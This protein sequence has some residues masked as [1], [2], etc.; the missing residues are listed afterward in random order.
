MTEI[1]VNGTEKRRVL[2][3]F[4]VEGK[5]NYTVFFTGKNVDGNEVTESFVQKMG[6][7]KFHSIPKEEWTK[8]KKEYYVKHCLR[9]QKEGVSYIEVPSQI[10]VTD[11]GNP[12]ALRKENLDTIEMNYNKALQEI[13]ARKVEVV[14]PSNLDVNP[15]AMESVNISSTGN[16]ESNSQEQASM[17][18]MSNVET[19]I[20]INNMIYTEMPLHEDA[21]KEEPVGHVVEDISATMKQDLDSNEISVVSSMNEESSKIMEAIETPSGMLNEVQ[22]MPAIKDASKDNIIS[23]PGNSSNQVQETLSGVET[24][25]SDNIIPF[26]GSSSEEPTPINN[27]AENARINSPVE[28]SYMEDFDKSIAQMEQ[29]AEKMKLAYEMMQSAVNLVKETS[30]NVKH[31]SH[32]N[33]QQIQGMNAISRQ[34]FENA[35]RIANF[36]NQAEDEYSSKLAA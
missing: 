6:E 35:Q 14:P 23:F 20:N 17:D 31:V 19:P 21:P 3:A 25:K 24:Q 16:L 15:V 33:F 18:V 13:R 4:R 27:H 32:E 11:S 22:E 5:D 30:E 28:T 7:D 10:M 34:T 2:T 8:V 26:P 29:A 12:L 1:L 36:Q 9:G